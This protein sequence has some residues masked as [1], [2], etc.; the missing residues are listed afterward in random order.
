MRKQQTFG[1]V[2]G[3]FASVVLMAGCV[4]PPPPADPTSRQ[5]YSVLSDEYDRMIL[6]EVTLASDAA[7]IRATLTATALGPVSVCATV[8][9]KDYTA[10][11]ATTSSCT[12]VLAVPG[13]TSVVNLPL[14]SPAGT[15]PFNGT[16]VMTSSVPTLG[17]VGR[18]AALTDVELGC[19]GMWDDIFVCW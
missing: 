3:A 14:S 1:I 12:T 7:S 17:F 8:G 6:E 10:A 4:A 16:V 19:A 9:S 5:Y 11:P 13:V 15:Y 18:I 2:V